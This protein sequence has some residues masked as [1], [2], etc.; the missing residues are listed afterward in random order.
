MAIESTELV[1]R[2]ATLTSDTTPAQNGGRM[3]AALMVDNLLNNLFPN[4][5]QAQRLAGLT[6][7]R[8]DFFHIASAQDIALQSVRIYIDAA[9]PGADWVTFSPGTQTDTQD[10][11]TASHYGT[12]TLLNAIAAGATSLSLTPENI[13]SATALTPWRVGQTIRISSQP[14]DNDAANTTWGT[15]SAVSYA[16]DRVNITLAAPGAAVSHAA[17]TFVA[18][19]YTPSDIIASATTPVV[20]SAAGTCSAVLAHNKGAVRQNWTLTFLDATTFSVAGDTLGSVGGVGNTSS[21][22]APTNA[23]TSSPYFTLASTAF[24]GT[25]TAGNTVTFTTAPATVPLWW[26]RQVPANCPS[27]A[28]NVISRVAT[29]ESA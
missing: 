13:A 9:T 6:T 25:F 2:A 11:H 23:G 20:T 4:V 3:G 21:T 22:T 5:T 17:G 10:T 24:G 14:Y 16:A 15:I 1:W 28:G 19:V 12:A 29:G 8:K 7:W 26:R 18:G 27:L